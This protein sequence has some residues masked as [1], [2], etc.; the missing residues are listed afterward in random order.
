MLATWKCLQA[1]LKKKVQHKAYSLVKKTE[2]EES[3]NREKKTFRNIC[4]TLAKHHRKK[5]GPCPLRWLVFKLDVSTL[6]D[7][8]VPRYLVKHYFDVSVFLNEINI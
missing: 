2:T 8:K 1:K 3:G 7:Y 6:L 5:L 4:S